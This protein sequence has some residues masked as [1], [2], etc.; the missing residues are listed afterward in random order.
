MCEVETEYFRS[1]RKY[2]DAL[3]MYKKLVVEKSQ[4]VCENYLNKLTSYLTIIKKLHVLKYD[5][6]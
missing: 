5:A 1:C 2:F 4:S 6:S 3:N